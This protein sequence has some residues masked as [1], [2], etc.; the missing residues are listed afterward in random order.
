MSAIQQPAILMHS[1]SLQYTSG[2]IKEN[3]DGKL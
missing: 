3:K 1:F 2:A